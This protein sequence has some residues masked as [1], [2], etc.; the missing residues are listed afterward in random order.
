M[1]EVSTVNFHTGSESNTPLIDCCID[2]V[3][4]EQAPLLYETHFQ[5]L[6]VTYLGT[7]DSLLENAPN[8]IIDRIEVRTVWRP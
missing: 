3:L 2:D 6:N 8:F 7:I 4:T 1:F 5:M